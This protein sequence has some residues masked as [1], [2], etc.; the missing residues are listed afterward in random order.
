MFRWCVLKTTGRGDTTVLTTSSVDDQARHSTAHSTGCYALQLF[1]CFSDTDCRDSV[2]AQESLGYYSN[3]VQLPMMQP[4]CGGWIY[5]L[6]RLLKKLNNFCSSWLKIWKVLGN[7][8][9]STLSNIFGNV[10]RGIGA[11]PPMLLSCDMDM[12]RSRNQM[13]YILAFS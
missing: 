3:K 9:F 1:Q 5:G 10:Y 6:A 8:E 13:H 12:C 2:G 4:K 7:A 11:H